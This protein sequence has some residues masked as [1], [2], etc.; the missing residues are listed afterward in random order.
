ML[1]K[2]QQ[3]ATRLISDVKHLS[4]PERLEILKLPIL[5]YR[6]QRADQIQVHKLMT[7]LEELKR[8]DLFIM[9]TESKTRGHKLKIRK[10]QCKTSLRQR[11]FAVRC[12]NG[13]NGLPDSAVEAYSINN[14]KS[15]LEKHWRNHP[16]K[17]SPYLR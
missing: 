6:R 12:I 13:W 2:V 9:H 8:D 1:E 4:Y 5:E 14:F 15:E 16:H 17:Y 7:G 3:R 11:S 10:P